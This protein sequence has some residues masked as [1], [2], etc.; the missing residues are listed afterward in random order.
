MS[1]LGRWWNRREVD[2]LVREAVG[3]AVEGAVRE[4]LAKQSPSNTLALG[5]VVTKLFTTQLEGAAKMTGVMGDFVGAVGELAIKRSAIALGSRGGRQRA[6]N[7]KSRKAA[8]EVGISGCEVCSNPRS[9]NSTAI[10]RHVAEGHD[11]RM[12][13]QQQLTADAVRAH[14]EFVGQRG[15]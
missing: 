8:A 15:N 4:A 13:A 3:P 5:E 9:S 11:A 14:A 2:Q 12:R 1:L 6:E 7:M 10:V